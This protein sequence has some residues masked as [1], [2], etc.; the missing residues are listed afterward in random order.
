MA[1]SIAK[2]K[3]EDAISGGHTAVILEES[4]QDQDMLKIKVGNLLPN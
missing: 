1:K 4:D 2:E 3:Y